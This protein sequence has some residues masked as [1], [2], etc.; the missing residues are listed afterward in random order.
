MATGSRQQE[1]KNGRD[2][3][4]NEAQTESYRPDKKPPNKQKSHGRPWLS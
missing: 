3:K 1:K 4:E 2:G